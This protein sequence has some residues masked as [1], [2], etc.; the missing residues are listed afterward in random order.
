[1]MISDCRVISFAQLSIG[2]YLSLYRS[3]K[4]DLVINAYFHKINTLISSNIIR[5]SQLQAVVSIKLNFYFSIRSVN[6]DLHVIQLQVPLQ[7]ITVNFA[8][9]T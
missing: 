1:M 2:R 4:I 6:N 8:L 3:T 9:S 7:I 5:V